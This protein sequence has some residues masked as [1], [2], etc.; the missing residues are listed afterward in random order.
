[1]STKAVAR[2]DL[3][4]PTDLRG[5]AKF[6]AGGGEDDVGDRLKVN[7]KTGAINSGSQGYEHKPGF[8]VAVFIGEAQG[9]FARFDGGQI[10]KQGWAR[11]AD[12]DTDLD[13][14]RD[15]L[16]DNNPDEWRDELPSGLPK[17]PFNQGVKVPCIDPQTGKLYTFSSLSFYG[18]KAARRLI[19][20]CLVQ[21]RAAPETTNN[22]VPLV[23]INVG[24]RQTKNGLI[25]FPIFEVEDWLPT[26]VVMHALG[27]GGNAGAFGIDERS[28][29]NS[30]LGEEPK[31]EPAP[32]PK[33]PAKTRPR[34]A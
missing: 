34:F 6:A 10:V 32:A 21:Q 4:L 18:V 16:G 33:K 12:P 20:N 31:A 28:A 24:S 23:A 13:E 26:G 2:V 14:L 19:Q 29:L 17:D 22:H 5:L 11:L 7:G 15:S 1:M 30:D 8:K 3:G 27:K 9:G 25:Y